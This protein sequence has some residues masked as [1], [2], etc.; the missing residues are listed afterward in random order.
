VGQLIKQKMLVTKFRVISQILH[1][2]GSKFN[3]SEAFP[4]GCR[5]SARL[6]VY[7]ARGSSFVHHS[8]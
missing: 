6:A 4:R 3:Q 1:K 7:K 5:I 8:L 2:N